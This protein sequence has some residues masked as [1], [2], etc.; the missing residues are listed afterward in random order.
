VG[1]LSRLDDATP[2]ARL[3]GTA[4]YHLMLTGAGTGVSSYDDVALSAWS[5]DRTEDGDGFF[6]YLRD[7]DDGHVWSA[8]H[9]PVR[10]AA[11]RYTSRYEPGCVRIER[12]DAGIATALAACVAPDADL[13]V[14][15]LT[16]ENRSERAR[17]IEVTT[18]AEVVLIE[19]AAY[20]AHPAFAK[21]FVQTEYV[22]DG[23]VLLAHRRPRSAGEHHPWLL[24]A[25]SGPGTAQHET[26]RVRFVG[27]GRTLDAPA[28]LASDAPLTGTVG[29]VLDPIVSLRRIVSLPPG[30]T[31]TLAIVLG[32]AASREAALAGARRFAVPGNAVFSAA[33]EQE[34][35]LLR[36]H[37]LSEDRAERLQA[38]A[39]A[40]RYA[41][42]RLRAPAHVLRRAHGDPAVL[43]SYDLRG[44][45]LLVVAQVGRVED[46]P[47]VAELVAARA[48][49]ETKGLRA[50]LVA[51]CDSVRIAAAVQAIVGTGPALVRARGTV[52]EA[53]R[54]V[55]AACAHLFVADVAAEI[56]A[57]LARPSSAAASPL[58]PASPASAA[59]P[60]SPPSDARPQRR[61]RDHAPLSPERAT[62]ADAPN[63]YGAFADDGA[64]YRIRV[65]NGAA[66]PRR[67]PMPWVNV[68]ANE[69]FGFLV[70]ESGAACTWS[71]NS[72]ENRL[73][74][75]YNDTVRDPHGE[76]LY[77]RD[78]ESGAVWSPL[79]GPV[80]SLVP[81]APPDE[82]SFDA[83]HG[84]GY[85][86]W[87]HHSHDLEHEVWT[88]VPQGRAEPLKIT[89]L[90]LTNPSDRPRRLSIVAYHRLVLG[91]IPSGSGRFI[92]TDLDI[93]SQSIFARNAFNDDFADGVVFLTALATPRPKAM[94]FTADRTAFLGRHGS[95]AAPA[96]LARGGALDGTTGAG[97]DACAAVQVSVE[98]AAHASVECAVLLG[99]ADSAAEAR[100]LVA[101]YREP[102]AVEDALAEARGFWNDL[103]AGV[104]ITTPSPAIDL[105]VN[106][107]LPYQI[108]SCRLWGR[109]AFYQS[110]GA[111]GFRDQLQDAAAFTMTRPALT[112]AQILLHA[113]H[114]FVEGDVLHWWHPPS[115]RGMRTRFSDDLLWLPYVTAYYVAT[116]G[117]HTVLD[118]QVGFVTAR[119]LAP[120]EDEA[121]LL[122]HVA[123]EVADVY[124]HCCRALDRSLTSGAHDLPLMGTGDW[125]DGMNRVGR[126]GRGE[127]VWLAFFLHRLIEDFAPLCERRGDSARVVRYRAYQA[128]LRVAL[129]GAGWDGAWYRRAYYDDGTPLGS[130]ADDECRIDALAQAWATLSDAVPRARAAQAMD[131]VERLLV[132]DAHGLVRLL[133]PPFDRDPHDPGY[134]KGYVPGIRENGGQYT[135]AALWV[136]EALAALGRRDR[137]AALLAALSPVSHTM[138][139]A[140]V[141]TYQVEPYVVAADV[142]GV[143]PHVGRGGWTWYTGSA[144]WMYRIAVESILGVRLLGGDTLVI[145]PRIPDAWPGFTVRL[146]VPDGGGDYEIVV[147]NPDARAAAVVAVTIDGTASA[148]VDGTA[149]IALA[150]DGRSHRI[151]VTL[152]ADA[153]A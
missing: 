111:F 138:T 4:R 145:A 116:T 147:T 112:R 27:R 69:H 15:R 108:A 82:T 73:T 123:D 121:Y 26:D 136:V 10:A 105:L 113:A 74:P 64:E 62:E 36:A 60:L 50:D 28:A 101:R 37:G 25:C 119:A 137:A 88:Y 43:A 80:T 143:P 53:E 1:D 153:S 52:P 23:E 83:R 21:L 11:E 135:H 104:R 106:G 99:E 24:H 120:G 93:A 41:D 38:L 130:A 100:T 19:P 81:G 6:I 3:L 126:E 78:E 117:D 49:W 39:G 40:M 76:A 34:R 146:R 96:A 59:L 134:I 89:R 92:V 16:L 12:L 125:N 94:R 152:G 118:E 141:A 131:A 75:W 86:L 44:D 14:R 30:E 133:A 2:H 5:A 46:A 72:R 8:G 7:L 139:P 79:P 58:S 142:Y 55:L 45:A 70:S 149:R 29:S 48:Y 57:A 107:W 42:P 148:I 102:G 65:E 13:E 18:Y 33:A 122:P 22:P 84:L 67:P 129:D 17:R 31:A 63:G 9:E 95:P 132:D 56:D 71:G 127:S 151:D 98:I 140:Q 150:R 77:I 54:D 51:L 103:R 144:G 61:A 68:I 109:S 32:A 115:D 20:A 87:H 85:S 47:R 90:R 97:L 66:G 128:R 91:G 124:T 35:T 114:Q 110:G